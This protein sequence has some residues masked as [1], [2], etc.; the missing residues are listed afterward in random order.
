VIVCSKLVAQPFNNEWID[1]GKTYYKF[2]VGSTGLYRIGQTT[3]ASAGL[4]TVPAE[5]FQLWRNGVQVPLFT[6]VAT[7]TLSNSDFI[8]FWGEMNDGKLDKDL[9][10]NSA[11]QLSDKLS[12][13]TDTAAFS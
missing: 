13:L 4:G 6:S 11:N 12:L 9:Y 10:K 3:L 7:G 8:E 5:Q 1:F 2:K